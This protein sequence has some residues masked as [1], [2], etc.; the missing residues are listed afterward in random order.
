MPNILD[1]F[2]PPDMEPYLR[3]YRLWKFDHPYDNSVYFI[4]MES[5][6]N[7]FRNH[8][9]EFDMFEG[10]QVRVHTNGQLIRVS[11]MPLSDNLKIICEQLKSN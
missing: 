9:D 8:Y 4:S 6:E 2:C 1:A 11:D 3:L 10:I 7:Y 5:A